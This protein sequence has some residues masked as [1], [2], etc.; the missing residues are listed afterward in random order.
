MQIQRTVR[1]REAATYVGLS[2][3]TLR[4]ARLYGHPAPVPPF[5]KIGRSIR[6]RLADLD[7]WLEGLATSGE[8]RSSRV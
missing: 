6:Y 2:A 3:S 7:K 1:E 4:N 5:I 8:P